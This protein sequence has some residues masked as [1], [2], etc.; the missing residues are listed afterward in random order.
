M[1]VVGGAYWP[2]LCF[3]SEAVMLKQ[4]TFCNWH[5]A[6]I[7]LYV[8]NITNLRVKHQQVVSDTMTQLTFESMVPLLLR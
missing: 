8:K 4:K 6:Y 5:I 7:H 3:E 2:Y 1:V